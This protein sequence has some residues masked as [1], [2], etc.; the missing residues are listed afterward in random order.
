MG[1]ESPLEGF[2]SARCRRP[3]GAQRAFSSSTSRHRIEF[4]LR[5]AGTRRLAVGDEAAVKS[6]GQ[7]GGRV[8]LVSS[9]GARGLP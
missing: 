2:G 6:H 4:T 8:G 7:Q 9:A 1:A 5:L 3:P